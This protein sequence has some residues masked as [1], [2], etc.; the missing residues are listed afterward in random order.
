MLYFGNLQDGKRLFNAF[1]NKQ[2]KKEIRRQQFRE[3]YKKLYIK[4]VVRKVTAK[5]NSKPEKQKK[6]RNNN[7]NSA[8]A[9]AAAGDELSKR[10]S[11]MGPLLPSAN[12]SLP[13]ITTVEYYGCEKNTKSCIGP[14]FNRKPFYVYLKKHTPP[15]CLEK[16]K[17]V[18][19]HVLEEFENVGIRYWLDNDALKS[20]VDTNTGGLSPDAYE[21]DIS[22]NGFDMERSTFLKKSQTRP[23]TD[24]A[25]FYWIK[26]TDGYYFR[27]QYS[28]VNQI[29]VNLLPFD[30]HG[31]RVVPSGFYGWK[32]KEFSSEFLHPMSTVVLLGK[33]VMCPNNVKEFLELK[34]IK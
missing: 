31:D 19:H 1:H 23:F 16:L 10:D 8:A 26:A 20:A 9:A 30:L 11:I 33:N 5:S 27:V 34:N 6:F 22:F 17:L 32:A 18:F 2:H 29:G 4:K 7:G 21:I 12:I 14:V 28:K 25:G 13:L 3:M 15:C 24:A